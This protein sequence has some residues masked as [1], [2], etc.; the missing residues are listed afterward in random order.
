MPIPF[1]LLLRPSPSP[2][3]AAPCFTHSLP[4]SSLLLP[5]NLT[6]RSGVKHGAARSFPHCPAIKWQPVA[7]VGGDQIHLVPVISEIGAEAL[8]NVGDGL[9]RLS[10]RRRIYN[11]VISAY[12]RRVFGVFIRS[13]YF[14]KRR[15]RLTCLFCV[16]WCE[17]ACL[18]CVVFRSHVR[19]NARSVS[20]QVR[21]RP[22]A[23]G[24]V[25]SQRRRSDLPQR[26]LSEPGTDA[27]T[28]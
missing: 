18:F 28:V 7:E 17:H 21:A 22:A 9:R 27:D 8:A 23:H 4:H 2:I 13:A 14:C 10:S 19:S 6:K 1:L 16:M 15:I 5:L 26:L 11:S 25:S 20:A 24:R 12:F 3:I